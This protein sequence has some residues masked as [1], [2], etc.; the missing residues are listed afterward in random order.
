M[1][2]IDAYRIDVLDLAEKDKLPATAALATSGWWVGYGV[3]GSIALYLSDVGLSWNTAQFL[4]TDGDVHA[5]CSCST[6]CA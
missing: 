2:A 6:P 3:I 4:P 1:I 5:A